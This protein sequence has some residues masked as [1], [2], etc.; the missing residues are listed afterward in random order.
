MSKVRKGLCAAITL[1]ALGGTIAVQAWTVDDTELFWS[2]KAAR[3]TRITTAPRMQGADAEAGEGVLEAFGT[4]YLPNAYA[5]Y[6][7]K[8][9]KAKER[10]ALL[11]EN[12]PKGRDSDSTGGKLYDK[13]ATSVAKAVAEMDRRHDELCHYYLLHKIGLVTEAELAKIDS[14][15]ISLVLYQLQMQKDVGATKQLTDAERTFAG[16]YIPTV[17]AGYDRLENTFT[18]G[19]KMFDTLAHEAMKIDA[20]YGVLVLKP[21]AERLAVIQAGLDILADTMK[22]QK[23]L[24]AVDE[25]TVK[26]LVELDRAKGVAIQSFEKQFSVRNYVQTWLNANW[27]ER[28][29]QALAPLVPLTVS[30]LPRLMV[31]IPNKRYAICRCEVTQRL[32]EEVMGT[33]P[34]SWKEADGPV[35][36]V[37]WDDCQIFLEKLNAMPEVKKSGWTYRLPTEKEWE[38][39]CRAGSTGNYYKLVDG[40]EITESTLD[41]VA[42]YSR[43]SRHHHFDPSVV[44][45]KKPNAFGLYDMLGNVWEWCQDRYTCRGGCYYSSFCE[46]I[47]RECN[48]AAHSNYGFRLAASLNGR[49]RGEG[50][51]GRGILTVESLARAMVTIPGQNYAICKYEVTQGLWEDVM[52][53]IPAKSMEG[54]DYPVESVSWDDCQEFVKKL[55]AL[56]EVKKSGRVYRLPTEKEWEYA[57]RAGSTGDYCKLANGAEIT[58]SALGEVAWH[59][60]NSSHTQPV[61]R[62]KPNAFGLYDMHGNVEEWCED[63][64]DRSDP[65]DRM[66]RG[67]SYSSNCS[68]DCRSSDRC[69]GYRGER[70]ENV[71]FRLAAS[72]NVRE[73]E[74]GKLTVGTLARAMVTIPGRKYA[75]CKYEVTQGLWEEVMG[76]N[77]SC[78]KETNLPV[79]CVSWNECQEFIKRLNDLPKVKASGWI[80]RL[81]TEKEWEYACRAGSTGDYCKLANGV[82]ITKSTLSEVAWYLDNSENKTHIVGQKNPN[83]FGLYD[84]HGNVWEWCEDLYR[85][86][87]SLRVARG[88]SW[89][90]VSSYCQASCRSY[91]SPGRRVS[92]LGFRLV[93]F[94]DVNR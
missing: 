12:F 11:K 84:M 29:W 49:E 80:Y 3:S 71:G 47:S 52:R 40:T 38:Y 75:I 62:K 31:K 73:R 60:D 63:Q 76:K 67:G 32:W 61:G 2:A 8:R 58:K 56:P 72:M 5:R 24:H 9:E 66:F 78:F 79:E 19:K 91:F 14:S 16:K 30:S 22:Q 51:L 25:T 1:L 86:G 69:E 27:S 68:R 92:D 88:G 53:N 28:Q 70:R 89:F 13:I 87:D 21:L 48:G 44:G 33:N 39:A 77:P 36:R 65:S 45:L 64:S 57:C 83:A 46:A 43:D 82:E 7:E 35:N 50:L 55:N 85:A 90:N 10:E 6:Q 74:W 26:Q 17:L 42:W 41:E 59:V 15:K 37:S 54:A 4:K 23:L 18:D 81:P 94:R 93:A 34:S 20:V